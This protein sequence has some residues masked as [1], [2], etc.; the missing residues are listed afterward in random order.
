MV[1]IS[2]LISFSSAEELLVNTD[3]DR[4]LHESNL[5]IVYTIYLINIMQIIHCNT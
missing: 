3:N 5:F 2:I 1:S 4:T